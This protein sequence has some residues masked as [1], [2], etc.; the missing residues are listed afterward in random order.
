MPGIPLTVDSV[1]TL[2][3]LLHV[4]LDHIVVAIRIDAKDS[5]GSSTHIGGDSWSVDL[6]E[7]SLELYSSAL[8]IDAH[9]GTYFAY[10][11]NS[12]DSSVNSPFS[13][14]MVFFFRRI[15]T[16]SSFRRLDRY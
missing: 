11:G 5:Y 4:S 10:L 7:E 12:S 6:V 2:T 14:V 8:V 16:H 9:N 15:G 1:S 13:I 3:Q